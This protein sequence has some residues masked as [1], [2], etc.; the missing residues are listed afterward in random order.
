VH[1]VSIKPLWTISDAQGQ[2]LS[3]KLLELLAQVQ[4]HGSLAGSCKAAG[5][6]YRHAWNLIRQGEAQFGVPLLVMERGKGSVLTPT[7]EKLVW[8]GH[9]IAARLTPTLESLSSELE[10]ELGKVLSE[11]GDVL[12]VHASHGFAVEKLIETL[13]TNGNVVDRKYVG[14]QEAVASFAEGTCDFAGFHVPLGE[15]EKIAFGHYAKWLDPQRSQ[16]VHI[17]TRRMGIMVAPGNPLSIFSVADLAKP[18]VRFVNR[19]PSS[20]THFLLECFLKKAQVDPATIMGFNTSEFTHAAV[21]AY[22]ASGMADAGLGVET[23]SRRFKLEFVPLAV[24]RYFLVCR[25]DKLQSPLIRAAL[26]VLSD[27]AFHNE[28]NQLLGYSALQCGKVESLQ[29]AFPEYFAQARDV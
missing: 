7:A 8:A 3:P 25:K 4:E 15:F 1:K 11:R 26:K 6:S 20:G 13:V 18:G 23:P 10:I 9:R 28:V 19:Q 17:A 29:Q 5:G 16:L 24:E 21:A 22:V 12:R 27:P 14:S 2:N